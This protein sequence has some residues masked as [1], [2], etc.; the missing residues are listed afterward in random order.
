MIAGDRGPAALMHRK[1]GGRPRARD[2][3]V[4]CEVL[5]AV[6]ANSAFH[7]TRLDV[8]HIG[9]V[10]ETLVAGKRKRA[11]ASRAR[12]S[13]RETVFVSHETY[14]PARGGSASA[15]IYALRAYSAT[16]RIDRDRQ[17]QGVH[18]ARDGTGIE[19]V[20]AVKAMET[21]CV[22]PVANFKEVDPEWGC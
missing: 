18:R 13:R 2:A 17:H 6:T 5:S 7:G 9:H 11:T 15:E 20:V 10:M 16:P 1:R 21:G 3:A 8:H 4:I 19:D 22:P 12:K 14:T